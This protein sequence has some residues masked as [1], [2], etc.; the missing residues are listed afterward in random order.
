MS[1]ATQGAP[2]TGEQPPD[3][4]KESHRLLAIYPLASANPSAHVTRH[5]SSLTLSGAP[6]S[7]LQPQYYAPH[8]QGNPPQYSQYPSVVESLVRSEGDDSG[9]WEASRGE[10]THYLS[11][12]TEPSYPYPSAWSPP[13]AQLSSYRTNPFA[14]AIIQ[15]TNP[16][17]AYPTPPPPATSSSSLAGALGP[18]PPSNGHTVYKP[19]QST[20]FFEHF[21]EDHARRLDQTVVASKPLSEAVSQSHLAPVRPKTPQTRVPAL[22]DESPDPLAIITPALTPRKRKSM[23]QLESPTVKRAL[24]SP[25]P[26]SVPATPSTGPRSRFS[27]STPTSVVSTPSRPRMQMLYVEVPSSPWASPNKRRAQSP[28]DLGGY[29][30]DSS[31]QRR[32]SSGIVTSSRRTGE[33]DERAPL[34]KLTYI[35][36]AIFEA[37][38]SLA[39]DTE[40][41]SLPDFFSRQTTVDCSQP[42]LATTTVRKLTKYIGQVGKPTKRVRHANATSTPRS[43]DQTIADMDTA[44]L[45]RI[46]KLLE[47]SVKAGEDIDPFAGPVVTPAAASLPNNSP[48][49]LIKKGKAKQREDEIGTAFNDSPAARVEL[50]DLDYA[51]LSR[52]LEI[53]KDSIFAV[54]CCLALLGSGR[55]T[56]QLYSEELITSCMNAVKNQL[57]TIIYPFVE[58]AAGS[59]GIPGSAGIS[60]QL[61]HVVWQ[62]AHR[63]VLSELFQVISAVF[64]QLSSLVDADSVSMSDNIIIQSVYIAIGPFFVADSGEDGSGKKEKDSAIVIRTFG[65]SAMRGLRLHALSLIRAVSMSIDL[66]SISDTSQIFAN[67]GDQRDWIIEEILTSLIKLSDSKQRA[68]QF[69]LRD[70]R[71]IRTVSALLLQLVQTSAHDVR[72]KAQNIA[73]ERRN[74]F[75]LKRAESLTESQLKLHQQEEFLDEQDHAETRLY[76]SGLESA[77]KAAKQIIAFLTQRSGKG[78][79]TKTSNEA[80][81]RGI[82][83]NLISD[84]LAVLY[85]P[86]Y[87]AASFILNIVT[88]YMVAALEDVKTSGDANN[89]AKTMALDHLGII[90]ARIRCGVLKFADAAKP[91]KSIDRITSTLEIKSLDRLLSAHQDVFAHLIKRSEEEQAYASARELTAATFAQELSVALE[92]VNLWMISDGEGAIRDESKLKAFGEKLKSAMHNVWKDQAQDVFDVGSQEEVQRIDRLSEEIGSIQTL[93]NSFQPILN[94][95]LSALDAPAIFMRTKAL[96][97]LGQIVMSDPTILGEASVRRGIERP[98]LDSS[99]AVRDA[100]VELIGKYMIDWPQVAGDYYTKIADRIADTGLA[101]RKRVIKLLKTFYGIITDT[102]RKVDICTRLVKRMADEDESVQELASKAIEELWFPVTLPSALKSRASI[103][104]QDK[105]ALLSK[106]VV[107]MGTSA[108]FNDRQS[109]LEDILHQIIS[110]KQGT[111]AA[112]LHARYSEICETLIDGLV[113]ASDLPGFTVINCVRAIYLFTASYPAVL[114]DSNASTLLPYLKSA[115]TL[116]EQAT[117]EYLLKIFRTSLGHLPKTALKFGQELQAALQPMIIKPSSIGGLQG[118]QE[119]VSCM[120]TVVQ[121]LTHDFTRLV[122]LL[123]SCNMRVQQSLRQLEAGRQLAPADLRTLGILVVIVSLLGEHFDF[124]K[125][126]ENTPSITNDLHGISGQ[127]TVVEHIYDT[128]LRIYARCEDAS[129]KGRIL[130]CLGFL[131]RAQPTLM[132]TERSAAVM[133]DIFS[134]SDEER[135]GRLL[136]IIQDFLISE[137]IK[138]SSKLKDSASLKAKAKAGAVD[139][140]ELV[141]NTDGFADSGVSSAVVQR[142]M[143]HILDA[144]LSQ[145]PAI[146][147]AAVDVLTFTIKQGLAHP[148]QSFPI[149][150][151]LETSPNPNLASRA[152][153]LHA[154]MHEKH[155]SLLNSRFVYSARI[156]FDYQRKINERGLVCGSRKNVALLHPWYSLVRE[157]RAPRQEFLR[158]LLKA[159]H[160]PKS[161]EATQDDVDFV[162]YMAENFAALDYKTQEEPIT[163]IKELTGVLST[164]GMRLVELVS[165]SNLLTQ[166]RGEVAS[167]AMDVDVDRAP[168]MR[169]TVV[170]CMVMMLKTFLKNIY[171]LSEEKCSKFVLG[172]KSALGDKPAMRRPELSFTWDRL[173]YATSPI[174]TTADADAQKAAFIGIWNEDGITAE[175]EDELA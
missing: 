137:A 175:P 135:R 49:K 86:E 154:V 73:Q 153:A 113:D 166:L 57:T 22:T 16:A 146:Q 115:S 9:F 158:S 69:R 172:K 100:A 125:A 152:G 104:G 155:A 164:E 52:A 65:K 141:G 170:I 13:N 136:K 151:A 144:A 101:V 89:A 37:E 85:W 103:S 70:G 26:T 24:H 143:Q 60:V 173:N 132:T 44:I 53:G 54:Q 30:S 129:L 171:S 122:A 59:G 72:L 14:Q 127:Y 105:T 106:V 96:R 139:M 98:L 82:F 87:P 25:A 91:L 36:E 68:G 114:S 121:M 119:T 50:S 90:A 134:S 18:P 160:L 117:S 38:D 149:I 118:L 140:D 77:T 102:E 107:I 66:A 109:P 74:K 20:A 83:D 81:Y 12:Q 165:P 45:S 94:V 123:K 142:Y 120:C 111:E 79:A 130:Q 71:T 163:V 42:L 126:R 108:N 48:K 3:P 64:P 58:V 29:G 138:H 145:H 162:R 43:R 11:Q 75:A 34:E 88:K 147:A 10:A 31:P 128:L 7:A 28:D 63:H 15:R 67:H 23:T 116:E 156:S 148:L 41:A 168:L 55:L 161:D 51:M 33:H 6:P 32:S 97:A 78:K 169:A 21:L 84:L 27:P 133:D 1:Y 46:L 112:G 174:L 95:I 76:R 5:L 124:E 39:P 159:F 4:V 17:T 56:K 167:D 8:P 35:L 47:R 157:K 80:E 19:Q 62:G 93:R 131:F 99:S 150:V 2:M 40:L 61:D 92:K 110:G